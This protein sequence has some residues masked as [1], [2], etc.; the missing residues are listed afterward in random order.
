MGRAA[1]ARPL[2]QNAPKAA[3]TV[4]LIAVLLD[5]VSFS[6]VMPVMPALITELTGESLSHAATLGGWL[7]FVF[8]FT[9]FIFAPFLGALSDRFGRRPVL[10]FSLV[11]FGVDYLIM[12][13]APTFALLFLGRVLSGIPGASF[14]PAFAYVADVSSPQKRAQNFGLVGAAFASGF[15][16]GP[17]FGGLLGV[18]GTRAPFFAAAAV[19]FAN[20]AI[21]YFVLKES[22][23]PENRR[24]F[25]WRR[26][27]PVGALLQV[28]KYPQVLGLAVALTLWFLAI[29]TYP[30]TWAF[31][32]MFRF[33]WTEAAIGLSLAGYGAMIAF[34]QARLTRV[35][36]ARLGEPR[37][38]MY[39]LLLGALAFF[40][41]AF[42]TEGWQVFVWIPVW[43]VAALAM[44]TINAM[45]SKQVPADAQGELQG[46]N[47]SLMSLSAIIGPPLMAGL[48]GTFSSPS[49]PVFFPGA[50]FLAGGLISIAAAGIVFRALRRSAT[51]APSGFE[52]AASSAAAGK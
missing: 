15:V 25:S 5:S 24:A 37:T 23:A 30:S 8:A 35:V 31:Y 3:L 36:L 48:F 40:G 39:G 44:P 21:G 41:Q 26:A 12:G 7:L 28:R 9:Q 16:I 46:V 33:G 49:A 6:M 11:A 43:L 20:F 4:V 32:T 22:L 10:L 2:P 1:V 19:A 47:A 52:A 42:A 51:S 17:A 50:A 34:S 45:M 27:N 29:Q 18:L 38:V 13:L 14:T